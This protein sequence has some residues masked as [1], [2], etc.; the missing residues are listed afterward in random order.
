MQSQDVILVPPHCRAYLRSALESDQVLGVRI[1][2]ADC[3]TW[4]VPDP[5]DLDLLYRF[6]SQVTERFWIVCPG[7]RFGYDES[8]VFVHESH[9]K[10][11]F[12]LLR[13][14]APAALRVQAPAGAPRLAGSSSM[15]TGD[16]AR[17]KLLTKLIVKIPSIS[18]EVRSQ[19]LRATFRS[20]DKNRD[21]T[22]SREEMSNLMRRVMPTMSGADMSALMKEADLNRDGDINYEEFVTWLMRCAPPTVLQAVEQE[23]ASDRDCV[24]AVF[25]VWDRNGD[26][27]ISLKELTNVVRLTCPQLSSSQVK[28]LALSM[29]TNKNG[30]I[31]YEEFLNFLFDQEQT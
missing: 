17:E 9:L 28:V 20:I 24:H 2:D 1:Q 21:G 25:R 8:G 14:V 10:R 19:V 16:V 23:L 27:V 26:G 31:D 11:Y 13:E 30:K 12:G 4:I 22:L 6:L 18:S 3:N 29:D 5:R 7:T 15:E